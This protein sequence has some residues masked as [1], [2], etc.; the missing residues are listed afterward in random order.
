MKFSS[1]CTLALL[2][3]LPLSAYAAEPSPRAVETGWILASGAP[4]IQ[5]RQL[6]ARVPS[7]ATAAWRRFR[8][9]AGQSWTGSFDE[10]S[11]I[12]ARIWGAGIP[13][14]GAQASAELAERHARGVLEQHLDLLA[15]GSKPTDFELVSND[16]D[17][18]MRTLGF[19]QRH[20][21]QRVLGGQ[22]SF[23]YKNDRLF[24]IGSEALP[25]V[26]VELAPSPIGE[27]AARQAAE[28]WIAKQ[29]GV[30]PRVEA[31]KGR[32]ILPLR[33][34]AEI[35]FHDVIDVRV[36]TAR[37]AGLYAVYL[38]AKNGEPVARKQLLMFTSG[39]VAFNVPVRWPGATRV[40]RGVFGLSVAVDGTSPVTGQDGLLSWTSPDAQ[41]IQVGVTGPL[42]TIANQSGASSSTTTMLSP[43]GSFVWNASRN[44]I[45]DAQLTAFV[46]SQDVKAYLRSLVPT[47]PWLNQQLTVNTNIDDVCNAFSDGETTN[48][49][50]SGMGCEN[51]AR[52]P[53]VVVHESGH[54]IHANA[55]IE[56]VGNFD[57][58][59]SEGV[60]D[61]LA[62]TM[63]EDP[64][65]GRGFFFSNS[66]LRDIDPA[67]VEKQWPADINRDPH[68]TGLIIAGALWDLRKAFIEELG[69]DAGVRVTDSTWFAILQRASDIPTTYAEAIA[70]DDD[71]GDLSNGTPHLCLINGAFSRHGLVDKVNA[72]PGIGVPSY[73]A[74]NRKVSFPFQPHDMCPGSGV[75]S[76]KISWAERGDAPATG[77]VDMALVPGGGSFA[78]E[79]PRP[80]SPKVLV[81]R[82]EIT[83]DDGSTIAF[84]D[85]PAD[86]AYQVF[87]GEVIPLYCTDFE[88]DP[89]NDGWSHML[90]A[91]M[92]TGM[93]MPVDDWQWGPPQALPGSSDPGTAPSGNNVIGND[94]GQPG[95]GRVDGR[96]AGNQTTALL[97]PM[98]DTMGHTQ[99]HVQF[100][101]WLTVEDGL[102]DQ[103]S[104]Y[105]NS[106]SLWTNFASPRATDPLLQGLI[107]HLDK[108][109]RF[110][111]VD[112]SGSVV[113]GKVQVKFELVANR[114]R[115][116]GGWTL[117]D[118]CV[119]AVP[120]CGNGA[121]EPGE[122]CDD[123]NQV[124]DD[125]C[126]SACQM[127]AIAPH[128]GNN[129]VEE[130]EQCDDGVND[131]TNCTST[132]MTPVRAPVCGNG[133]VEMGEQCDDGANN[134]GAG[135]SATC[136]T[137]L[138]TAKKSGCGC[139]TSG[140][141][142]SGTP[143]LA[144][145]LL[146]LGLTRRAAQTR[147]RRSR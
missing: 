1:T 125:G 70:L 2:T 80:T 21:G 129:K 88:N 52:L 98:V 24:M 54:T 50:K 61:Y 101:R 99:V 116:Y 9:S 30:T 63:T 39:H 19:V 8:D 22:L 13:A 104:I 48:F 77:I 62:A 45:V 117:D 27:R 34:G 75:S 121:V 35:A 135:C 49:F 112:L 120:V 107:P 71:D 145:A 108:E 5:E 11:G 68:E 119:V 106:T 26:A 73:E 84:P 42:V 10:A 7:S 132:C 111:D 56:G 92:P 14:M 79:L 66:P 67:G 109:W 72:G 20:R 31:I 140:E 57:T 58:S 4:S 12:P 6:S 3:I 59:L 86:P 144:L 143:A 115:S 36:R 131:G 139:E 44:E 46:A 123:M 122:Q 124:E 128:C 130:G 114:R 110:Q 38:D 85:N 87:V 55:V 134:G 136:T 118:F 81:Y 76:A 142:V 146:A 78:G 96:Y 16:F 40:D 53:D 28:Q 25:N 65:M 69:H 113:D 133:M 93:S 17:G 103:A 41:A 29:L 15:P 89:L 47:M 137:P 74:A 94:L 43:G 91:G 33:D 51:T 60:S 105:G 100:R 90:V 18:K 102:N 127:G 32:L 147:R 97:S 138:E 82:V 64:Q 83:F 141:P 95:A 23:R 37:P 126:T